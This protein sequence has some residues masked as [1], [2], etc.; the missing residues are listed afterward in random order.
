M[1]KQKKEGIDCSK[2]KAT[3]H[4]GQRCK[5]TTCKGDLCW[6]HLKS[7]EHLRVKKSGIH[8]YGLYAAKSK[9]SAPDT[10]FKP[11]QRIT[12][13]RGEVI[14]P[15]EK[16][17][18]AEQKKDDYMADLSKGWAVDA[19]K[20]NTSAAR[21]A[22][23]CRGTGKKCNSRFSRKFKKSPHDE[24]VFLNA[25]KTIKDGDEILISYGP[26]YWGNQVRKRKPKKK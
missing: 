13:Y 3:T 9:K 17:R 23:D 24:K 20:T 1:P 11:K 5:L 7:K 19:V 2:C 21:Y 4:N 22:N 8:G 14:D 18:R 15:K 10:V 12:Q 25:K 26:G 6:L 16:E